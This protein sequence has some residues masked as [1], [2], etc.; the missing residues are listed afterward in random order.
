M[1][2]EEEE[3]EDVVLRQVGN[4]KYTVSCRVVSLPS[5]TV[6]HGSTPLR[7]PKGVRKGVYRFQFFFLFFFFSF[8]GK[9]E[10]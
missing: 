10:R 2:E 5:S 4:D 3:E 9:C 1:E 6:T 8:E 7:Y